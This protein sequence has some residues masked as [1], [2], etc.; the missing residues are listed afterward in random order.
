LWM[1][2]PLNVHSPVWWYFQHN[3]PLEL[4]FALPE[5]T[6]VFAFLAAGLP[7]GSPPSFFFPPF[8]VGDVPLVGVALLL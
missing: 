1:H 8:P 7:L 6:L 5:V 4:G 3:S 2:F